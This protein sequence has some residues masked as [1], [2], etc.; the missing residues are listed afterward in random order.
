MT[1]FEHERHKPPHALERPRELILA[2]SPMRSHVNLSRI[3]RTASCCGVTRIIVCGRPRID[4]KIA[5]D[6]AEQVQLEPHRTLA[7]VLDRLHG[8]GFQLVGL[9]QAR[10]SQCLYDF[11]FPRRT[12]LVVGNERL[13]IEEA[14]LRRLDAVI[15][16]P[17]YGL[18][19]SYNVSA[20]VDMALYEYCRQFPRG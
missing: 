11:A 15:E 9:E 10:G 5:R 3:V 17:V 16:I 13:G 1:D 12:A 4:P 18:P 19:Y 6:A 8:D 20:A 7:P 2:C 14:I